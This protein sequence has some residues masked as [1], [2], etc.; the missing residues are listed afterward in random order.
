MALA[1]ILV[2]QR[3][4][5]MAP[6]RTQLSIVAA[7]FYWV[8]DV[9]SKMLGEFNDML[10][11][12]R[13]LMA[14]NERLRAE[15]L[16]LNAKL[17]KYIEL[18]AENVRLRELMNS[19]ELLNDTVV[20]AEVVAVASD[21]NRHQLVVD[22]GSRDG[23]FVGQPVIDATGLLGQITEVGL[24]QSRVLLITDSAHALPVRVSRNGL[25]A[26]AEGTGLIDEL[27]LTHVAATT[28]I[29][30]GDLLVSSGLGGRFPGGYPVGEVVDVSIDPGQ[31][32]AE[33]RARP[34]AQLDRSRNVLLVFSEQKSEE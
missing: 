11:S 14:D 17:Q 7:P 15:S 4:D 23:A 31:P 9:P 34:M 10:S 24:L 28:D 5:F 16:I 19:A 20:V 21:P 29:Q 3:L 2:G 26:I 27:A 33:V 1:L 13:D 32:F 25:R 12:R 6:V 22:K 8:V 18:R 30:V